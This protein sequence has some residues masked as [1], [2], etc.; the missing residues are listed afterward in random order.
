MIKMKQSLFILAILLIFASC[1]KEQPES[2]KQDQTVPT[3]EIEALKREI[4]ELKAQLDNLESKLS[5]VASD[6]IEI[7]GLRFDKNGEVISTPKA[8]DSIT[9]DDGHS[10]VTITRTKD[11]QGRLVE[12]YEEYLK[13]YNGNYASYTGPYLWK[14]V[15]YDYKGKTCKVTTQTHQ[16]NLSAD[17]PA[18]APV[19]TEITYW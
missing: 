6:F 15:T 1:G 16:Y 7:D 9:K 12:Y 18:D 13:A 8:V 10:S 5:G 2:P 4:E 14:R 17:A 11:A 3:S 19:V